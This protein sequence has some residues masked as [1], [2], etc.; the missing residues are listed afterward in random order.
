M[1]AES[2]WGYEV[3]TKIDPHVSK[4]VIKKKSSEGGSVSPESMRSFFAGNEHTRL[5]RFSS[6]SL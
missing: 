2:V 5:E 6:L 3:L 4:V 1:K